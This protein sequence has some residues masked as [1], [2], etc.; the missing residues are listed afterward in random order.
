MLI[1]DVRAME[2]KMAFPEIFRCTTILY[3]FEFVRETIMFAQFR[4]QPRTF[5]LVSS[6]SHATHPS[7]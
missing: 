4:L 5:A 7:T 1:D 2:I 3:L 6:V